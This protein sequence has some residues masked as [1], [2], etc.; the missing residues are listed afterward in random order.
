MKEISEII[1]ISLACKHVL[2]GAGK[3]AETGGTKIFLM[4]EQQK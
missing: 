1:L 4:L 2:L 3:Q